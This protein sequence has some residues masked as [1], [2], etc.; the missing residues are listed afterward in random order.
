M[1]TKKK[2]IYRTLRF[3]RILISAL[4]VLTLVAVTVVVLLSPASEQ[5]LEQHPS[6]QQILP[7]HE[8]TLPPPPSNPYNPLDF[9]YENGYL[10]CG[11]GKSALGIDVS[12]WQ[13]EIDWQ[14]V[15]DAGVEFVIIR[16]GYRGTQEGTLDVDSTAQANYEG[17]RAAGLKVGAYFFSQ[18]VSAEEA[19]EEARFLLETVKDWQVDMP[20]VYD[21]EYVDE[22]A[23][24][25]HVDARTLTDATKAF[26]D[27]VEQAGYDSMIYFNAHQ[28]HKQ[29]FLPEL[30]DYGFW[31]AFYEPVMDY[32]YKIDMWQY[33]HEG[34]VPGINGNVDI[35]LQLIYE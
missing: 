4:V 1:Q 9:Y 5:F 17:A 28:S 7:V 19:E 13:G 27:T 3:W 6:I 23:R 30:K 15:R 16:A 34:T 29:M 12:Y 25:A 20:L 10:T 35:N 11:A 33:T 31:L 22:N 18:A 21:W 8:E 32:P 2:P 14:Q 26:C 24:T